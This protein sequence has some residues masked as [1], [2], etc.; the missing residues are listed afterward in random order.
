MQQER[1]RGS[2]AAPPGYCPARPRAGHERTGRTEWYLPVARWSGARGR[3]LAAPEAGA[4]PIPTALFRLSRSK[5]AHRRLVPSD[6]CCSISERRPRTSAIAPSIPDRSSG[7]FMGLSFLI[8]VSSWRWLF[9]HKETAVSTQGTQNR[10]CSFPSMAFP[11]ILP[12]PG[13]NEVLPQSRLEAGYGRSWGIW[14]GELAVEII[15]R[16]IRPP[17]R[18]G[19]RPCSRCAGAWSCLSDSP[20]A[21][22]RPPRSSP[23]GG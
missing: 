22:R 5:P 16:S 3:G 10:V 13:K 4:I 23:A 2:T 9:S 1:N 12:V 15:R 18:I 21:S 14:R 7:W 17:R 6:S 20:S 8:L 11:I 19:C